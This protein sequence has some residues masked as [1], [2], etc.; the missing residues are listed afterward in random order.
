MVQVSI[1]EPAGAE[2]RDCDK[3][4]LTECGGDGHAAEDIEIQRDNDRAHECDSKEDTHGLVPEHVGYLAVIHQKKDFERDRTCDHYRDEQEFK[5]GIVVIRQT[6]RM[7]G[8]SP[9]RDGNHNKVR[10]IP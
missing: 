7:K 4:T 2:S 6:G 8:E 1:L 5:K 9:G 3:Y 10:R